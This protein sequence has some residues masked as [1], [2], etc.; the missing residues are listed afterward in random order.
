[1]IHLSQKIVHTVKIAV[2]REQK[3]GLKKSDVSE[4]LY[5]KGFLENALCNAKM[6]F[7]KM[8][9]TAHKNGY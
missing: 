9:T 1:M 3:N 4:N 7:G 6:P 8:G 2:R 5:F